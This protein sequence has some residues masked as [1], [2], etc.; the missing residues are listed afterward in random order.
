MFLFK[1]NL[2]IKLIYKV[3]YKA[4]MQ[5]RKI[6]HTVLMNFTLLNNFIQTA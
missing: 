6:T 4:E 5:V 1:A 3:T 2:N